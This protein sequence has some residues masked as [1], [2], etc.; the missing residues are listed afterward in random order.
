MEIQVTGIVVHSNDS[1]SGHSHQLF[2]T[3]WDG[4][5]VNV[6]VHP[7]EGDTSFDVGHFHHYVGVT[8][9]APSGVPHVHKYHAQTSFNDQHKHMIRGT[10]GPAI[11]LAGG[12]HYHYFEGYTT[13]DGRIPHNHRYGG[14]TG[15]ERAKQ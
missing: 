6:H 15:N 4:R 8:E 9:P 11:P 1:D 10:T 13:I 12:G 3:S 14:N 2:L 5:P 7:F